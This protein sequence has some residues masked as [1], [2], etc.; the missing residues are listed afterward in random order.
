MQTC[1]WVIT[2]ELEEVAKC[3]HIAMVEVL[4]QQSLDSKLNLNRGA[5]AMHS[6]TVIF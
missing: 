5:N 6:S 4:Q 3:K 2:Q 1:Y